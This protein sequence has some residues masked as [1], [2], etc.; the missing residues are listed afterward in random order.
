[1]GVKLVPG[2]AWGGLLA[3]AGVIALA[4]SIVWPTARVVYRPEFSVS[5]DSAEDFQALPAP[6]E[7]VQLVWSWGRFDL[8]DPPAGVEHGPVMSNT[9]LLAILLLLV[10]GIH[11][12]TLGVIG[13]TVAGTYALHA[14]VQR[15]GQAGSGWFGPDPGTSVEDTPAGVLEALSVVLLTLA[16]IVLAWR[17]GLL[18]G[19][20]VWAHAW[21]R[22]AG[23]RSVE[24]G[25][26]SSAG[27]ATPGGVVVHGERTHRSPF[28]DPSS[29]AG[30][31]P[32]EPV[33]FTDASPD[34]DWFR[35]TGRS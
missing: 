11:A 7:F 12:R 23:A 32:T 3:L 2:R 17:P 26:P 6:Q 4:P 21:A 19:R 33:G 31:G 29:P 14:L 18:V 28:P 22:A 8:E 30:A 25:R 27:D 13:T 16:V 1:M 10:P 5:G 9:S 15:L 24:N 20:R 34:D 35:P